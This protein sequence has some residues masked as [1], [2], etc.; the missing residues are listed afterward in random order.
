MLARSDEACQFVCDI[1]LNGRPDKG[2]RLGSGD[3]V[4]L[5]M[6]DVVT[7]QVEWT[8]T[9]TGIESHLAFCTITDA[10]TG[11]VVDRPRPHGRD[12][13]LMIAS[14]L[15][16]PGIYRVRIDGGPMPLTQLVMADDPDA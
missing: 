7:P 10:D 16:A 5:L 15:P 8:A 3:G 12:G 1:L 2:P 11:R 13:R 9:L 4:G 14:V 6:P